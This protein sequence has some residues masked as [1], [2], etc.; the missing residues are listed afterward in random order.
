M[1]DW[2]G[3]LHMATG[4]TMQHTHS[5][6]RWLIREPAHLRRVTGVRRDQRERI[7]IMSNVQVTRRVGAN[8][9]STAFERQSVTK[10]S[11]KVQDV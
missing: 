7:A 8:R 3:A 10:N 6:M 11:R 9:R 2:M 5:I 1:W 4:Y